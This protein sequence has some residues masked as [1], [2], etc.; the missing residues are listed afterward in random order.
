M[1]IEIIE[2]M[3]VN[4]VVVDAPDHGLRCDL[5]YTRT[6]AISE[7]PRQ[8]MH[9]GARLFMDV[10]RATQLGTWSG[11]IET[12]N[13]RHQLP[14]N[15]RGTKDRSW[16]V[17][18]IGEALPGVESHR[19]PQLA[20]FWAPLHLGDGGVHFMTFDD[21]HGHPFSR[22]AVVFSD[23]A[24]VMTHGALKV[25]M[26]RGTR[27]MQRAVLTM[28]ERE[29]SLAPLL[30]FQMRGAGYSHPQFAHGRW[31][32]GPTVND[33]QLNLDTLEPLEYANIHVQHVVRATCGDEVG[34]GV[35][36]QLV[37]GPYE[38][39]GLHGLLDGA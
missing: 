17:R 23:D 35:L 8:T 32:G 18:P 20:F 25:E 26:H 24:A 36:E 27:W 22:S 10:T 5:T 7:E 31:H 1:R 38:P 37:I 30:R 19:A 28:G 39:T 15:F 13:G 21:A 29:I 4:R 14:A 33:E 11:W 16:G 6:T 3:R 34:L 12:P 2:P 9:D